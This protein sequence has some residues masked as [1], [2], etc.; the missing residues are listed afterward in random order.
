MTV[1]HMEKEDCSEVAG[2]FG[3]CFSH[4]WSKEAVEEMFDVPGYLNLI[5]RKEGTLCGYI[6]IK[7]VLDEADIVNV[8]VE[9]SC[10]REGIGRCL[11]DILLE[12]AKKQ[13]IQKIYLEVRKSNMAAIGLYE[14]A[15]FHSCGIRKNYY[16]NPA[17]DALLMEW[18]A[19]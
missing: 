19:S 1:R 10:R 3:R 7:S 9:P 14:Q 5:A 4:P 8:A 6:G 13:E 17:E 18:D 12:Q 16:K 15:G 2:L 11:L